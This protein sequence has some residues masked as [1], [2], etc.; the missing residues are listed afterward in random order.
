MTLAGCASDPP[1]AV[2]ASTW[3]QVDRDI[4]TASQ[5][6]A[7]QAREH[8]LLS[9]Q[10]WMERVYQQTDDEFIPW[11][12]G[13]WTQQ[14]LGMKVSWYKLSTGGDKD[15]TVSR[16][17]LY[18]QEQYQ[19]RVLEPV[20]EEDDPDQI[21]ERSTRLYVQELDQRLQGLAQ[22]HAVPQ[23]QFEQR[24]Q[25]VPAITQAPGASLHEL[26][27]AD[28]LKRLPAYV[29]LIEHIRATPG[30]LRDWSTDPGIASV[31]QR[32]SERLVDELTTSSAAS[33]VG[34]M[35]G[36][37]AGTT[38]SLGV[39]IFTAIARENKRPQTE[40]QLRQNLKSAFEAE[41]QELMR[42]TDHGVL[43]GVHQLSWR[44]ESGLE[45]PFRYQPPR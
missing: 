35:V 17:A 15:P 10:H 12:S 8:A 6:A 14:W 31:A 37:V 1:V 23:E 41:W 9:M 38:L 29:G 7:E 22:R 2:S 13:Y 43:A 25:A 21:M 27:Q 16:L 44:I 32:T 24:L 34:A 3:R 11:F 42:N 28:P 39:A 5:A 26:L 30:G 40:A 20:A 36:R 19:E 18:L 4:A 33:A 45:V